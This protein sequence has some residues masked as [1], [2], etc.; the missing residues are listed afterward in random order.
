MATQR[1]FT[2]LGLLL[3]IALLGLG[4]ST[5]SELWATTARRQ[6]M[7]QLEWVGQQYVQGIGSYYEATPRGAKQFPKSLG[8]LLEDKRFPFIRRHQR[9]AY[10]NP[11][12]GSLDWVVVLA[13]DGGIRCVRAVAGNAEEPWQREFCYLP[14]SSQSPVR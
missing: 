13:P 3:A 5:A 11:L 14:F 10:V 8:D 2:Y 9:R 12:T 7:A 4:L 1:G 6:R